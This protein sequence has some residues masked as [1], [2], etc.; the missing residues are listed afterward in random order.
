MASLSRRGNKTDNGKSECLLGERDGRL[1]VGGVR[2]G[3]FGFAQDRLFDCVTHDEAVSHAAQ[4]D[5]EK[6][7]TANEEADS[8]PFD[9][10][11]GAE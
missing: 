4:D 3:S 5:S 6:L 8:S 9:F 7:T 1:W 2:R 10:A 11:Q